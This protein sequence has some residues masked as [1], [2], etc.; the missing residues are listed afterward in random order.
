MGAQKV[1]A[2]LLACGCL[3][4]FRFFS[5]THQDILY[6]YYVVVLKHR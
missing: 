4:N 3:D 1:A 6:N 5:V 2:S